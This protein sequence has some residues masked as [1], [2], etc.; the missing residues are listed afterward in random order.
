[1]CLSR[2]GGSGDLEDP[3][4]PQANSTPHPNQQNFPLGNHEILNRDPKIRG[5]V[6]VHKPSLA[7]IPPPHPP[8]GRAHALKASPTPGTPAVAG[9][10]T[11]DMRDVW[12]RRS[13]L[14]EGLRSMPGPAPAPAPGA[15]GCGASAWAV[16]MARERRTS[17]GR[18]GFGGR[19]RKEL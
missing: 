10:T 17:V 15:L 7:L 16:A 6:S 14:K 3:S 5:A 19:L 8:L 2:E 4:H 13:L 11:C 9:S 1:M 12:R 18:L